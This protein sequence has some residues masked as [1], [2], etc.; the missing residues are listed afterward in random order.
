MRI[1]N[2]FKRL[3]VLA[4]CLIMV[5]SL[6]ACDIGINNSGGDSGVKEDPGMKAAQGFYDKVSESQDLLDELADDIYR[7]WY[8]CIYKDKFSENINLAIASAMADNSENVDK[9]EALDGEIADLFKA[10]KESEC[11]DKVKAVMSAYS[12]YY[13]LVINISGSFNSYSADKESLKKELASA[14]KELSFEL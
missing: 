6:A 3:L 13:E 4:L 11:G 1:L 14:L 10:A 12:D 8:D 2:N 7:N 5:F 9:I